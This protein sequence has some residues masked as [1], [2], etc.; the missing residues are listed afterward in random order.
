MIISGV[1]E[2]CCVLELF[3]LIDVLLVD[4]LEELS[5]P[6]GRFAADRHSFRLR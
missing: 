5:L 1:Q 2:V 4:E 6:I 3:E